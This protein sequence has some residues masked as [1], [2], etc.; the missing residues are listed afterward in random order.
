MN[1]FNTFVKLFLY[2]T[3]YVFVGI[4]YCQDHNGLSNDIDQPNEP[5]FTVNLSID[6]RP[7]SAY[8]ATGSGSMSSRMSEAFSCHECI[9]CNSKSDLLTRTC[10]PGINMC[11]VSLFW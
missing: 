2:P 10:E 4:I 9:N 3:G 11:Y 1:D 5:D 7:K 8:G 6:T